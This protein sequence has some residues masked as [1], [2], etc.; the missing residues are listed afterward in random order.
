MLA[1]EIAWSAASLTLETFFFGEF[2]QCHSS[3]AILPMRI[4]RRTYKITSKGPSRLR[5][6]VKLVG[7]RLCARSERWWSYLECTLRRSVY[8]QVYVWSLPT[9]GRCHQRLCASGWKG[10]LRN[11]KL[12]SL[13]LDKVLRSCV[14]LAFV[15]VR[16]AWSIFFV[17]SWSRGLSEPGNKLMH[18]TWLRCLPYCLTLVSVNLRI[19]ITI[20]KITKSSRRQLQVCYMRWPSRSLK[21][22]SFEFKPIAYQSR[23]FQRRKKYGKGC[24]LWTDG[25]RKTK[26]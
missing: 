22:S 9:P 19:Q 14:Q 1:V 23:R 13:L 3:K 11:Q 6:E 17:Y 21:C 8:C 16:S 5:E 25:H 20:Q 26:N 15:L 10:P 2:N 4:F 18:Q 12:R 7:P 24:P